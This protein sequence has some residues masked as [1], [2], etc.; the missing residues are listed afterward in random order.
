MRATIRK[1]GNSAAV[2]M[3]AAVM[4]EAR[5]EI[6]QTVDVRV[7]AGRVVIEPLVT[8]EFTLD[9]LLAGVTRDNLHE[10]ED[11]GAPVG[12]EAL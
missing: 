11:F 2:R 1:W 4:E 6:D 9:A 3:S 12:R 5:L 7:E 10:E 8:P